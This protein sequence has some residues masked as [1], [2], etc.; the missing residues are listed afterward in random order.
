MKIWAVNT[1]NTFNGMTHTSLFVSKEDAK[2]KYDALKDRGATMG[3]V[4]DIW[5]FCARHFDDVIM[6]V[7]DSFYIEDSHWSPE[8]ET[9]DGESID[10]YKAL[11]N[12]C[13]EVFGSPDCFNV[14]VRWGCDY[15]G[16]VFIA[17]S[18]N[19]EGE[20]RLWTDVYTEG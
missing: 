1:S 12:V 7:I 6:D 17:V 20:N 11:T 13:Y 10:I 8:K 16:L 19:Y 18:W 5:N 15:G 9:E 14:N 2:A 4:D 3:M